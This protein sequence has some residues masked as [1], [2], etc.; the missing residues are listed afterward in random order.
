VT[1]V[2]GIKEKVLG[3][4]RAGVRT[5]VLPWANRKDAAHDV[6]AEAHARAHLVFVRTVREALDAAFGAGALPWREGEGVELVQS[7]L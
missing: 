3:A 4:H 1:P 6:P 5:V 2:G 7:R